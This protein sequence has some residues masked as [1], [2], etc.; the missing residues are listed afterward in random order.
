MF[1]FDYGKS[2]KVKNVDRVE[3]LHP[4]NNKNNNFCMFNLLIFALKL[5]MRPRVGSFQL[6]GDVGHDIG[7]HLN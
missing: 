4:N 5:H 7:L 1:M 2:I 6:G 3:G